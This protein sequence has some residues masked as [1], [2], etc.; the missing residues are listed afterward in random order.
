MI[1]NAVNA[2][3][4]AGLFEPVGRTETSP[5]SWC[6]TIDEFLACRH[7]QNGLSVERMGEE[8]AQ[9]FDDLVRAR[10]GEQVQDGTVKIVDGRIQGSCRGSIVW[11]KPLAA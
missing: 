2:V 11:G 1:W 6:P 10:I 8:R 4:E 5:R 7:S 9:A 3:E